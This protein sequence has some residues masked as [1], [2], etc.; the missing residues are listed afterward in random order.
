MEV[1]FCKQ[2]E[3]MLYIYADTDEHELYHACKSCGNTEKIENK[4]RLIYTNNQ[5]PKS[6]AVS[7]KNY[8]EH[9]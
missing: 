8:F 3:N 9:S 6:W 2:C 7:I 1:S 5:G 4:S